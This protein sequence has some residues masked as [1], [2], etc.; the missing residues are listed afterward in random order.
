MR[1]SD[2]SEYSDIQISRPV[3]VPRPGGA[4]HHEKAPLYFFLWWI[5]RVPEIHSYSEVPFGASNRQVLEGTR[6]SAQPTTRLQVPSLKIDW[7]RSAFLLCPASKLLGLNGRRKF[8]PSFCR[9]STSPPAKK[10][11]T[12]TAGPWST[13]P[14]P[15][16]S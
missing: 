6:F 4:S 5:L 14:P 13:P 1:R 2:E 16:P 7:T 9:P 15:G 11:P 3:F 10:N 12:D 8:C